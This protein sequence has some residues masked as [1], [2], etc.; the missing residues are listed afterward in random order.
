MLAGN[1]ASIMQVDH[2]M[3]PSLLYS[4]SQHN[5]VFLLWKMKDSSYHWVSFHSISRSSSNKP[6]YNLL[7]QGRLKAVCLITQINPWSSEESCQWFYLK[8]RPWQPSLSCRHGG[9]GP[10]VVRLSNIK[11]KGRLFTVGWVH[12]YPSTCTMEPFSG[13]RCSPSERLVILV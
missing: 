13:Q 10:W 3:N 8:I 5:S 9:S 12:V 7:L 6:Y 1:Q 11:P 2:S 4:G